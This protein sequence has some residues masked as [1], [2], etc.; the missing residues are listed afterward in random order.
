LSF[1]PW[2]FAMQRRVSIVP[3]GHHNMTTMHMLL[4]GE[5]HGRHFDRVRDEPGFL[6]IK[7]T[8]DQVLRPGAVSTVSDDSN[9]IHWFT[10][11][12]G[13]VFMFNIQVVGLNPAAP[14]GGRDYIDPSNGSKLDGG[15]IRARR[16]ERDEAYHLYG[17]A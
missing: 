12:T 9:N 1:S 15:L 3:H 8:S 13:P 14:V 7:P 17:L 11:L 4:K 16:L 5:V 10:A 6:I 2:L